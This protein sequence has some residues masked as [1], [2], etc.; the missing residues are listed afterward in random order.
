MVNTASYA[1]E[2]NEE[3]KA[4][5]FG[6]TLITDIQ[7]SLEYISV[8]NQ[9]L[10]H[11]EYFKYKDYLD[12]VAWWSSYMGITEKAIEIED[13]IFPRKRQAGLFKP[14]DFV[15]GDAVKIIIE[16]SASTQVIMV[17]EEHR[18]PRHRLL[19]TELLKPLY[20]KGYRYLAVETLSYD[21]SWLKNRYPVLKTGTYSK[22]PVFAEML[23]TA[24]NIGYTLVPYDLNKVPDEYQTMNSMQRQVFR[25]EMQAKNIINNILKKDPAAKIVVHGG[26]DHIAEVYEMQ[27][28][29]SDSFRIGTMAGAF[30]HFS[31]IDPFT[32]DQMRN[33]E[34]SDTAFESP[35][36]KWMRTQTNTGKLNILT[37]KKTGNLL[38]VNGEIFDVA[39]V[40]SLTKYINGRPSWLIEM[41]GRQKLDIDVSKYQPEDSTYFLVQAIYANEDTELAVPAD[42]YAYQKGR[43]HVFLLLK[44]G[45][46]IIRVLN[47]KGN[48]MKIWKHHI[49]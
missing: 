33:A 20:E 42:Q 23:R 2:K 11:K 32:I 30:K 44:K 24:V 25:E 3:I 49:K 39:V 15:I 29:G 46:Y 9:L 5:E 31:G 16:R 28:M 40:P 17:N 12:M 13:S 22:D 48:I 21:S 18:M 10:A 4:F 43:K 1:Q 36:F 14:A 37:D 26:R 41:P 38:T 7:S 45:N 47:S 8:F 34:H 35:V 6:N 19:T 27:Q